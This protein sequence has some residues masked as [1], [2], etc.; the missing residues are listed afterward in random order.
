MTLAH[1]HIQVLD[2][3]RNRPLRSIEIV[4][5]WFN[6][7]PKEQKGKKKRSKKH[8]AGRII[9]IC[10]FNIFRCEEEEVIKVE[11]R[12]LVTKEK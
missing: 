8:S 11:P 5:V 9:I 1:G 7:G 12:D 10:W 4:G 3:W 2:E 6:K